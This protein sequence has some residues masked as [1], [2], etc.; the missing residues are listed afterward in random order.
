MMKTCKFEGFSDYTFGEHNAFNDD[1]DNCANGKPIV[2]KLTS[3]PACDMQGMY[4]IGQYNGN[5]FPESLPGCWT[6]GVMQLDEDIP[7]PAWPMEFAKGTLGY[8]P[9]LIIDVPDNAVLKYVTM[10]GD[11]EE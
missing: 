10:S 3:G 9:R 11:D 1:H 4:V 7:L 8:S 5:D 2:W 6:I